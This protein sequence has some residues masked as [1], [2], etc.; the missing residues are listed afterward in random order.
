L[1]AKKKAAE[2]MFS[3][4]PLKFLRNQKIP[5]DRR[6]DGLAHAMVHCDTGRI[7][8]AT[9]PASPRRPSG[10]LDRITARLEGGGDT[11][12]SKRD[13]HSI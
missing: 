10:S 7:R 13:R 4:S 12:V 2:V 9:D 5:A 6:A 11:I 8:V 1:L 3:G